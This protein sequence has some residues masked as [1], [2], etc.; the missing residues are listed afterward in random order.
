MNYL[1]TRRQFRVRSR[2]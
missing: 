1:S 2:D